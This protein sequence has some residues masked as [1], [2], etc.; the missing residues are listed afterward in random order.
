VSS[1]RMVL[2]LR[3]ACVLALVALGLM[4]WSLFDPRPPPVL[5]ALS[6]GQALGTASFGLY[7]LVVAFD[8]RKK[9]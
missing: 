9:T 6:V 1:P 7:L 2:A 4:L 8:L 3:V 5:I